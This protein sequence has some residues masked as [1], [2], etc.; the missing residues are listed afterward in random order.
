MLTIRHHK[1]NLDLSQEH[2]KAYIYFNMTPK[3]KKQHG[4]Y[5]LLSSYMAETGKIEPLCNK[6]NNFQHFEIL[7]NLI[8]YQFLKKGSTFQTATPNNK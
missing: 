6:R 1:H 8:S 7:K 5:I 2:F 3:I 4:G